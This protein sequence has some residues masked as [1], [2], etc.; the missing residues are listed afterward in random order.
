MKYKLQFF[1]FFLIIVISFASLFAQSIPVDS[2]YLSQSVPGNTAKIF[3][4]PVSNGFFAAERL[5]ISPDS[6]EIYYSELDGYFHTS[7]IKYFIYSNNKWNGPFNLF[8]RFFSPELSPDGKSMFFQSVDNPITEI[9]YSVKS[10]TGW[11]TPSKFLSNLPL[12]YLLQETNNGNFYF[13]SNSSKGGLGQRDWSRLIINGTDTVLQSLGVPLCTSGDDVDFCVSRDELCIILARASFGIFISYHKP[14]GTWTNPKKLITSLG[15]SPCLT[16]DNKFL[17]F[18][19]GSGTASRNDTWIY[20]ERVDNLI[21]SLKHTNFIPY[22]KSA[23]ANQTDTAG[24]AFSFTIPDSTFIDDDG[25]NTLS[26]SAKLNNGSPLPSWLTFNPVTKTFSGT[27]SSPGAITIVITATDTAKASASTTF[28]ITI[29]NPT[30]VEES[31]NQ[32]PKESM[33]Y[34]NYPN[35]FNPTTMISYRITAFNNVKLTI[36]NVLGQKIKTLVNSFQNVGEHSIVW[37]GTDNSNKPINSGVYFYRLVISDLFG[38]KDVISM[39]K[40]MILLR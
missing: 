30:G 36:Y 11:S 24:H 37:N 34:Q 6:D 26:Y 23:I 22:L 1:F 33:L 10:E 31:K 17:F 19:S 8:E 21:D 20:W 12:Q 18:S 27:P 32:I 28:S 4:L 5:T 14:D 9:R 29:A 40:K 25:N 39:Q 7:R 2:T 3:R 38:G 15:W 13:S 35:P 16:S